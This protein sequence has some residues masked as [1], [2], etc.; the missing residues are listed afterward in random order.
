M[1]ASFEPNLHRPT[2]T[3]QTNL[4]TMQTRT[5]EAEVPLLDDRIDI[6]NR[7][8]GDASP[9]NQVFRTVSTILA[10]IRV[11]APVLRS[12]VNRYISLMA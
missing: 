4:A 6:L 5:R 3:P 11:G 8:A 2:I 9:A 12:S 7:N 1:A 10:L